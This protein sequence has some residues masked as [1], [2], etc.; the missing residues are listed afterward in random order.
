VQFNYIHAMLNS[1]AFGRSDTDIYATR[2]QI[3]F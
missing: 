3:E 1:T 2:F